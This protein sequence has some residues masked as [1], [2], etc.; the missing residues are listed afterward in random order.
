MQPKQNDGLQPKGGTV[1]KSQ[2]NHLPMC[3]HTRLGESRLSRNPKQNLLREVR[4]NKEINKR[5][6]TV[7]SPHYFN[8][9]LI[10]HQG[11]GVIAI[12][13]ETRKKPFNHHSLG[14]SVV[15]VAR[16]DTSNSAERCAGE[17]EERCP[18]RDEEQNRP[19]MPKGRKMQKK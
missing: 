1:Q 17:S 5:E 6:T 18:A 4:C 12:K 16:N 13:L 10:G 9:E 14:R 7:S 11:A 19:K 3:F 15:R 8:C 2:D